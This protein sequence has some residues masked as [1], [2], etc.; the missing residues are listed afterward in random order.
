[1]LNVPCASDQR[2]LYSM[3]PDVQ[4]HSAAFAFQCQAGV[5]FMFAQILFANRVT[6]VMFLRE[7]EL[8]CHCSKSFQTVM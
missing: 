5:A 1:M 4:W 2:L 6:A 3:P 7:I 8:H